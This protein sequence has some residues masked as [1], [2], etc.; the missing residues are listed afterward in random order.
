M[1]I[2]VISLIITIATMLI[3]VGVIYGSLRTQISQLEKKMDRHNCLIERMTAVE[4]KIESI[5]KEINIYHG[6]EN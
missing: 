4:T 3:S 2:Q 5:E 1:E 6:G